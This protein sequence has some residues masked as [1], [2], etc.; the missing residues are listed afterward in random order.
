MSLPPTHIGEPVSRRYT[1]LGEI[2]SRA[3]DRLD[4]DAWAVLDGGA[5]EEQTLH[6]NVAAFGRWSFRPST[7]SGVT[8]VDTTTSLLGIDLA[9]PIL[10]APIGGD[11]LFHER[12]Q[13]EI[14]AAT[15]R[16]GIAPVVSEAS[17]F[18]LERIADAS[19]GPKLMQVHAW[20]SPE[21]FIGL[22]DRSKAAGY[23]ALCVTIDCPTLGWRERPIVRR[24]DTLEMWN[25]NHS[26]GSAAER[27]VSGIGSAWTWETLTRVRED[28]S[29]PMLV[30]G[31]LTA[32][33]ADAAIKAGVDGVI[34]SNHGGRQLDC[35]PASLDQLP[36]VVAAVRGRVPVVV[37]GGIRRGTDVLKALALGAHVVMVGRLAAMALAV[38]GAEGVYTALRLVESELARSMLL[39]GRPNLASVDRSLLQR[40][41]SIHDG[42]EG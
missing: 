20:G 17:A 31:V 24:F 11:R 5:G 21:E 28:V 42:Y 14:V 29:L 2:F 32:E 41:G 40:R 26:D 8:R 27:L 18:P 23:R 19:D 33:D 37:D 7:L 12:G 39:A 3:K 13:C 35:V 4:A 36:E 25:A 6:D 1:T 15:A 30:K 34:V 10:T 22:A 38:D 9:F 16:A